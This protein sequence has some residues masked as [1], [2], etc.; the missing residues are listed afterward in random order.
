MV[1]QRKQIHPTNGFRKTKKPN[2]LAYMK[3]KWTK[4]LFS[5]AAI[6]FAGLRESEASY[7]W[8]PIHCSALLS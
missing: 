4:V 6:L 8:Y 3:S 5:V 7:K 2:G 1:T